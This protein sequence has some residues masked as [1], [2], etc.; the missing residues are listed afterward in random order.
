VN[1]TFQENE[2]CGIYAYRA[3]VNLTNCSASENRYGLDYFQ[4]NGTILNCI[5]EKNEYGI[6]I[7]G[8][9]DDYCRIIINKCNFTENTASAITSSHAYVSIM[10]CEIN[11][12]NEGVHCLSCHVNISDSNIC[13]NYGNGAFF[14]G[15]S[16]KIRI[17]NCNLNGN[18]GNGI[19][20]GKKTIT[21]VQNCSLSL[22]GNR[23]VD[24]YQANLTMIN[25]SIYNNKYFGV[26]L[27]YRFNNYNFRAY[28][29]NNTFI[30][31][32]IHLDGYYLDEFFHEI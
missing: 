24:A 16:V 13:D 10:N 31:N 27:D 20:T 6:G 32:T 23:G 11:Y 12:N 7:F 18:D 21:Y 26:S 3:S 5:S 1:C 15:D 4:S 17:L 9:S 22:N 28:I 8:I 25:N 19:H 30:N 29:I 14:E 2:E